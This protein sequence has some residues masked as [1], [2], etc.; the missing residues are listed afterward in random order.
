MNLAKCSMWRLWIS[1]WR[2]RPQVGAEIARKE[3]EQANK[4]SD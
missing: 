4:K 3:Q 1:A 2:R